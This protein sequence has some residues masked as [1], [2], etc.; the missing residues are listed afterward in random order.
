MSGERRPSE[1]TNEWNGLAKFFDERT[2]ENGPSIASDGLLFT[3][4]ASERAAANETHTRAPASR[5]S[6]IFGS[7]V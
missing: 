2:R 7:I 3:H 6:D 5:H 1:R 4:R